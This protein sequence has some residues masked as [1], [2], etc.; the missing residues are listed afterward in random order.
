MNP[1]TEDFVE[2]IKNINAEHIFILPNNSNIVM[3][4]QQAAIVMEDEDIHVI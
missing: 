3:A 1:S 2:A 4:A